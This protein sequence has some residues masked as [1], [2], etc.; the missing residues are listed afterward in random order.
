M[1]RRRASPIASSPSCARGRFELQANLARGKLVGFSGI[2]YGV[3]VPPVVTKLAGDAVSLINKWDDGLYTR[4][5]AE[6]KRSPPLRATATRL[7]GSFG[8]C[9]IRETVHE[10][11]GWGVDASCEHGTAHFYLEEKKS[12]LTSFVITR[13]EGGSP[14]ASL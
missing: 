8:A 12:K 1:P 10:A 3:A 14:C 13:T 2:S 11:Q 7:H 6:S 5:F 4:T 9:R